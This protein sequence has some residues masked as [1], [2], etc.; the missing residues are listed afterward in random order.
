MEIT[1]RRTSITRIEETDVYHPVHGVITVR[2]H[3][4]SESNHILETLFED[5][6]GYPIEDQ[7]LIQ[8]IIAFLDH[9]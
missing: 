7:N 3:Y 4:A 8:E 2:D 5:E 1:G 9:V 6:E